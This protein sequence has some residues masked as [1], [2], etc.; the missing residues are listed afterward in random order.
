MFRPGMHM[1][2]LKSRYINGVVEGRT[3][4]GLSR[5]LSLSLSLALMLRYD[6]NERRQQNK[7]P[8]MAGRKSGIHTL[9]PV[10]N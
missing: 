4:V 8:Y 3:D 10:L 6:P 2:V 7:E 9:E 5:S 1:C